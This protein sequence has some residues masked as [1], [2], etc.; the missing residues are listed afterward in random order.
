MIAG[1]QLSEG[2]TRIDI[3]DGA[4]ARLLFDA[5]CQLGAQL[6]LSNRTLCLF[7]GIGDISQYEG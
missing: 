2:L 6:E 4:L 7:H 5:G 1:L 3:Q